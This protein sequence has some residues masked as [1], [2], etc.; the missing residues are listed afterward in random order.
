MEEKK[1]KKHNLLLHKILW[2][3]PII[4]SFFFFFCGIFAF[5]QFCF[6]I[7][8]FIWPTE[9]MHHAKY[10]MCIF[11]LFSW[12]ISGISCNAVSISVWCATKRKNNQTL[13][14]LLECL[15]LDIDAQDTQLQMFIAYDMRTP[16]H[17]YR[18]RIA[19][20]LFSWNQYRW[21]QRR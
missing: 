15:D 17:K 11:L 4:G 8:M 14:N 7:V 6:R 5:E 18:Y 12:L 21:N 10:E 20:Y 9:F 2:L 13:W 1:Y 3:S 19:W 16:N